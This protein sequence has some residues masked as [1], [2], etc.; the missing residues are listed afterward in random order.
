MSPGF[1][2][3]DCLPEVVDAGRCNETANQLI[4]KLLEQVLLFVDATRAD[5]SHGY[6]SG[7]ELGALHVLT[8]FYQYDPATQKQAW[9]LATR[10]IVDQSDELF[11]LYQERRAAMAKRMLDTTLSHYPRPVPP[12]YVRVV[13]QSETSQMG[14]DWVR[15]FP[16]TVLYNYLNQRG[17]K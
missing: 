13:A 17:G 5:R 3:P 12:R 9:D 4:L 15:K 11:D 16:L 14:E 2:G 8:S 1:A 6:L 7:Y 10:G